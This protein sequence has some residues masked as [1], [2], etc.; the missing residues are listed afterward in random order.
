MWNK[1]YKPSEWLTQS[2]NVTL[3]SENWREK[4][5]GNKEVRES[6]LSQPLTKKGRKR[7]E[8]YKNFRAHILDLTYDLSN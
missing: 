5:M 1:I 2:F 6:L 3:Y 4:N 8:S 7:Y